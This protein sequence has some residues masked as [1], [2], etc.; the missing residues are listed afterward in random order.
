MTGQG[1]SVVA[2][3]DVYS[4]E[5]DDDSCMLIKPALRTECSQA[6][7]DALYHTVSRKQQ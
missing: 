1:C 6:I 4:I 3:A 7:C 5:A 2:L